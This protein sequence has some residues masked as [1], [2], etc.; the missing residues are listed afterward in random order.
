MR[1][2][3]MPE[4]STKSEN[5]KTP[6]SGKLEPDCPRYELD[7]GKAESCDQGAIHMLPETT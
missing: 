3:I 2:S 5:D 1:V 4:W 6:R 7:V